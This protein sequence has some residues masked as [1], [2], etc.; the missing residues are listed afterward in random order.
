MDMIWG[1]L[2]FLSFS[3]VV[4][5]VVG[6]GLWVLGRLIIQTVTGPPLPAPKPLPDFNSDLQATCRVLE[7]LLSRDEISE[8]TFNEVRDSLDLEFT[9][10]GLE[11]RPR[12]TAPP[13]PLETPEEVPSVIASPEQPT[14]SIAEVLDAEVLSPATPEAAEPA[15]P[16]PVAETPPETPPLTPRRSFADILSA[17]MLEKNIRWGEVISSLLIVGS[18]VGLVLSLQ[19]EL[20]RTIP[21]FPALLFMGITGAIHGAGIY[22]LRK[23]NLRS[24]SRGVLT[25]GLLLIPLNFL[26]ASLLSQTNSGQFNS[27][28]WFLTAVTVGAV[29]F[30]TMT[31]F[32][33]RS[34]FGRD[35][36]IP[37]IPILACS[38][39][40]P[41]IHR[42]V[43]FANGIG[44][45]LL[46]ALPLSGFLIGSHFALR[47]YLTSDQDRPLASERLLTVLG[48]AVFALATACGLLLSRSHSIAVTL[49]HLAIATVFLAGVFMAV[50]L[51]IRQRNSAENAKGWQIAGTA[52]ALTGNTLTVGALA[53]AWPAPELVICVA[54]LN[55]VFL[56]IAAVRVTLEPNQVL[57]AINLGIFCTVGGHWLLGHFPA[58]Q[59]LAGSTLE[60]LVS[61]TTTVA[62]AIATAISAAAAAYLRRSQPMAARHV[63]NSTVFLAG[64]STLVA[65]AAGVLAIGSETPIDLSAATAVIYI[66]AAAAFVLGRH[67]D[68][69]WVVR[70]AA[71]LLLLASIHGWLLNPSLSQLLFW[72]SNPWG[73]L[74][75]AFIAHSVICALV[76]MA[77]RDSQ[78]VFQEAARAGRY[79][80][81]LAVPAVVNL[82]ILQFDLLA[83][84]LSAICGV[85][86]VSVMLEKKPLHLAG[87]QVLSFAAAGAATAHFSATSVG[88]PWGWGL[89]TR[90]LE[91]L[92][93]ICLGWNLLRLGLPSQNE[94][95]RLLHPRSF[96]VDQI[97]LMGGT[98]LL[99]CCTVLVWTPAVVSE[100]AP[101][102]F[103][104]EAV[105]WFSGLSNSLSGPLLC[106]L[107]AALIWHYRRPSQ[108]SASLLVLQAF[109]GLT[110][111]GHEYAGMLGGG[112]ALR[113]SSATFTV[114]AALLLIAYRAA[115][116]KWRSRPAHQTEA[117]AF[118]SL[119]QILT[120]ALG[121]LPT[122]AITM[123]AASRVARGEALGTTTGVLATL[124]PE[125]NYGVPLALL[126][127][128]VLVYAATERHAGFARFGS[129]L[130]I[131]GLL[132]TM[133]LFGPIS[134]WQSWTELVLSLQV[135]III[136]G[137]YAAGWLALERH[138]ARSQETERPEDRL[139]ACQIL[140]PTAVLACLS[141]LAFTTIVNRPLSSSAITAA[142]GTP[143]GYLALGTALTVLVFGY[144]DGLRRHSAWLSTAVAAP[145]VTTLAATVHHQQS[146]SWWA[147]RLLMLGGLVTA[148]LAAIVPWLVHRLSAERGQD[149]KVLSGLLSLSAGVVAFCL[150]C[151]SITGDPDESWALATVV[152]LLVLTTG[153]A[154]RFGPALAY[155]GQGLLIAATVFLGLT[156]WI[157]G[158]DSWRLLF[159]GGLITSIGY[160]LFW[161]VME[162]DRQRGMGMMPSSELPRFH[163]LAA[164]VTVG[165]VMLLTAVET[166]AQ[167]FEGADFGRGWFIETPTGW[168]VVVVTGIL[169]AGLL[170]DRESRV[171][172]TP[173]FLWGLAASCL[174][175]L[176]LA[177]RGEDLLPVCSLA[178]ATYLAAWGWLGRS[179][180]TVV[181]LANYARI[182][183]A[184]TLAS[185]SRRWLFNWLI[186]LFSC[187]TAAQFNFVCQGHSDAARF[188]AAL[189]PLLAALGLASLSSSTQ[190][191]RV[192]VLALMFLMIFGV[193]GSWAD[194]PTGHNA[195][196]ELRRLIRVMIVT[197]GMTFLYGGLLPRLYR[198]DDRWLRAFSQ[199]TRLTAGLAL[200]SLAAILGVEL[201]AFEPGVGIPTISIAEAAAVAIALVA[202]IL[203]LLLVA[204]RPT[205]DPFALSLQGRKVYVYVAQAVAGLLVLHLW[206]TVPWMFRLDVFRYWPYLVMAIAFLSVGLAELLKRRQIDVL[207][208][209]TGVTGLLLSVVPAALMWHVAHESDRSAV[210]LA[211]GVLHL[212][213]GAVRGSLA[214]GCSSLLFGNLALWSFYSR[215][216][217]W[218]FLAHPQF[219]LIPPAISV[220][221]AAHLTPTRLGRAQM[222]SLRYACVL[223]IYVSSTS[224]IFVSGIG[225]QLWPP[226]LLAGL[227]IIGA[228]AGMALQIRAYLYLGVSFLFVSLVSMV[229]HAHHRLDHVW[230]WWA[231]GIC[232]GTAILVAFGLFEKKRPELKAWT[233]RLR[234]WDA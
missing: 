200:L 24:T 94:F 21:Y 170:W 66:Y 172:L 187:L 29:G 128:S 165:I 25:I 215:F 149:R 151:V 117:S 150:S 157:T 181:T 19:E 169:A 40:Q 100:L 74:S 75:V 141:L 11:I 154:F 14:T 63:A 132:V 9:R 84:H 119:P 85:W 190:E 210:L 118:S 214:L 135:G 102:D 96:T 37:A 53:L 126:L 86:L 217:G 95:A 209:P 133:T 138:T 230:P 59:G 140:L 207:A 147:F 162:I 199:A 228:F 93:L 109:S 121:T 145:V 92:G 185:T 49:D 70:L 82:Y 78:S 46:I 234:Q 47:R 174:P 222:A 195:P 2:C 197:A 91:V 166:L 31:Y 159:H 208:D 5:T 156:G 67:A 127:F 28:I 50:G 198:F 10:R 188:A 225:G 224:E 221:L 90:Q 196:L 54:L 231:F 60:L 203:G 15:P 219:W 36:W 163:R 22:T 97:A 143:V 213:A 184:S 69:R 45:Q 79:S 229:M 41:L 77:T 103:T 155:L 23:W 226:M 81:A 164:W 27:E 158:P 107:P 227:S 193:F 148:A 1:A 7:Q 173:L 180:T 61:S 205:Y 220:L 68:N 115:G 33:C 52:L 110:L 122:V 204:V 44:L 167:R 76:A 64:L 88:L 186:V 104:P 194:L 112:S 124:T 232:T 125:I 6:H 13:A 146:N 12:P 206:L 106:L 218:G 211:I 160:A 17:F 113:W 20:K 101:T 201:A 83:W 202:M 152:G 177:P 71:A 183:D 34:L 105:A 80:S 111:T 114:F 130:S 144:W 108:A 189:V 98:A 62:L 16:C 139:L 51:A 223:V 123:S 137:L 72:S 168:L 89:P 153:L 176:M 57:A 216:D 171:R 30:S 116:A 142:I 8:T 65:F 131:L 43:E 56:S 35:W 134:D 178:I 233:D 192:S 87:F 55:A 58:S 4:I 3:L 129:C 73:A 18:A 136:T 32:S 99:T 212:S 182:N 42:T 161:L 191:S 39:T 26:A 175:A 48:L 120:V 179:R 38:F